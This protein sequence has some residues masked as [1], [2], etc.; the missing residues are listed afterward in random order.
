MTHVICLQAN[1]AASPKVIV[2]FPQLLFHGNTEIQGTPRSAV[3]FPPEEGALLTNFVML[4]LVLGVALV[5]IGGFMFLVAA[6][7]ESVLWGLGCIF[8]PIVQ[9]FFLV[10]HWQEAKK[11]FGIQLLGI[12]ILVVISIIA[13]GTFPSRH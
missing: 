4:F 6:F 5:V 13:P 1:R 11:A 12:A 8:L 9:L 10:V 7:R 3:W 2:L